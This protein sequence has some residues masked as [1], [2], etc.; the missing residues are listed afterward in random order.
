[1]EKSLSAVRKGIPRQARND[2]KGALGVTARPA[3]LDILVRV[4]Y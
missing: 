1:V 4:G 2:E 3:N